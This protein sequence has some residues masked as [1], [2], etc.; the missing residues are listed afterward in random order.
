MVLLVMPVVDELSVTCSDLLLLFV[1]VIFFAITEPEVPPLVLEVYWMDAVPPPDQDQLCDLLIVPPPPIPPEHVQTKTS[2]LAHDTDQLPPLLPRL[3]TVIPFFVTVRA[4]PS[5]EPD[6]VLAFVRT[7]AV[8][9]PVPAPAFSRMTF[10]LPPD[11]L[12]L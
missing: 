6:N 7:R 3:T 8:H 2:P 4:L 11:W 5:Q 12:P 10:Q 9:V 1:R